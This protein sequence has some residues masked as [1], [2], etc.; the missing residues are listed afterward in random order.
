MVSDK[1]DTMKHTRRAELP[2]MR[3]M[4]IELVTFGLKG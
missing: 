4:R 1:S 3:P 2:V